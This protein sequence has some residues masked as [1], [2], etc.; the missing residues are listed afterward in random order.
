MTSPALDT[1]LAAG[2]TK[3]LGDGFAAIAA[4]VMLGGYIARRDW[5]GQNTDALLRFNRVVTTAAGYV[6]RA[7]KTA[8][9]VGG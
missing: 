2:T 5:I 4:V 1:S 6:N 7:N 3:T 8:S 9:I